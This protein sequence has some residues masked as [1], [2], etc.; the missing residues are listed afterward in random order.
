MEIKEI[1]DSIA[2]ISGKNDKIK[3]LGKHKDNELLKRVIY[4]AHSPRVKFYI[5]AIPEYQINEGGQV[6]LWD[7]LEDLGPLI[8]RTKTGNDAIDYLTLLFGVLSG[9]DQYVLE[10]IIDK[11]LKIGM[12]SGINKVIPNLIEETGYMGCVPFNEK[13]AKSFFDNGKTV[14]SEIK[15]DGRYVNIVITSG[16][17]EFTSR[18]GEP[19]FLGE[20]ELVNEL[21]RLTD[22]VLNGELVM[23]G[24]SRLISNGIIASIIDY[25]VKF[26][27]RTDV[28]NNKKYNTFIKERGMS[29]EDALSLVQIKVWDIIS[30]D[31]FYELKSS[32]K[33]IDRLNQLKDVIKDSDNIVIV[34]HKMVN[35][36]KEAME[37]FAEALENGEEGTVLKTLDG[38]WKNG[39]QTY[40]LKL[41]VEI[42][43]DLKIVGFNYGTKGTKNENVISS[44]TCESSCG[45]LTA[46]AQ[47][48]KEDMMVFVTENQDKLLGTILEI[49]CNG[50]SSNSNGGNSVFYPTVKE[51]RTDKTE[52]NSFDECLT[53][54]N[55]V[56]GLV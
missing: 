22:C 53:I 6:G 9:D 4:L 52:A 19:S 32:I 41:K 28:E 54:Q 35:S 55:G 38:C 49:K 3:E 24:Y 34:E 37:H 17:V 12:D 25:K 43:L 10:R 51:F 16:E 29:I 39:K 21:S 5:K 1:L 13:R 27:T 40:Q 50:L 46:R 2:I 18:Q 47:G 56:L 42:D 7:V 14:L 48:L 8:N 23:R 30:I 45:K 26:E 20:C 36:F 44:I 31:D 33:R 11:N 15:A